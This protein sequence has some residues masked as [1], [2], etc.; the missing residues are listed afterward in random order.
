MSNTA[1]RQNIGGREGS[2]QMMVETVSGERIMK[3]LC[4]VVNIS[5]VAT[6]NKEAMQ[7][8]GSRWDTHKISGFSGAGTLTIKDVTDDF[9]R[10]VR[11]YID[12]GDMPN[13]E[14]IIRNE[15]PASGVGRN[16]AILY[17]VQIDEVQVGQLD[18][19]S[20]TL[21]QDVPFTFEGYKPLA[22]LTR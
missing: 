20:A 8:V 2:V 10:I 15:D 6:S 5:A 4:N 3:Q 19:E 18:G 13:M 22:T 9:R 17:N 1:G 12:Y 16:I 14:L 11:D 7:L 21:N